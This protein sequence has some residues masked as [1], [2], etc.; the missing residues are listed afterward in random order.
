MGPPNIQI[1]LLWTSKTLNRGCL[2]YNNNP[3][4][5]YGQEPMYKS[6]FP[7]IFCF[8]EPLPSIEDVWHHLKVVSNYVPQK[9]GSADDSIIDAL[10]IVAI[11]VKRWQQLTQLVLL[12]WRGRIK[13]S[14]H[15]HD[16]QQWFQTQIY[17]RA[18]FWWKKSSR[19]AQVVK[20]V[21]EGHNRR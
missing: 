8:V 9:T 18:T 14:W 19:A 20:N 16:L 12:R 17:M 3:P 4:R 10:A 13:V 15:D 21:F 2:C 7:N 5:T 1:D 6:V 11:T